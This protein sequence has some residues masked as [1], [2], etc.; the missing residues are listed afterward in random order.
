M[1]INLAVYTA[2]HGFAWQPGSVY[3]LKELNRFYEMIGDFP[4]IGMGSP[5]FGGAFVC[6]G[7]FVFYRF[8]VNVHGDFCGR[9]ALYCVVGAVPLADAAKLDL[10]QILFAPEFA[11]P[12]TPFPTELEGQTLPPASEPKTRKELEAR[13]A[14][15]AS[16]N[17]IGGCAVHYARGQ[18]SCRIANSDAGLVFKVQ[19]A[20]PDIIDPPPPPPKPVER[21]VESRSIVER[22]RETKVRDAERERQLECDLRDSR[23]RC[24]KLEAEV[25]RLRNKVDNWV[26]G[27]YF[28]MA[29]ALVAFAVAFFLRGCGSSPTCET[30]KGTGEIE[31]EETQDMRELCKKCA[32]KGAVRSLIPFSNKLVT[33]SDCMGRGSVSRQVKIRK[34]KNCPTCGGT[35]KMPEPKS[36]DQKAK[37]QG[38]VE[39]TPRQ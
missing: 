11:A 34:R 38:S 12:M 33:C 13:V 22:S 23:E 17:D 28:T 6:D 32:G 3:T 18:F 1:K 31:V 20:N 5:R 25:V 19:C 15:I 30:C 16:P 24:R 36:N 27:A 39:T 26:N 8:H 21:P 4:D 7:R 2:V 14:A 37:A 9:D 10:A 35:G 29:L